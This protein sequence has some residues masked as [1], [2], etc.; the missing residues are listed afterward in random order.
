MV[1]AHRV[2][3]YKHGTLTLTL[4]QRE[5]E[6]L[7]GLP[8]EA[9]LALFADLTVPAD[10]LGLDSTRMGGVGNRH[11]CDNGR[12]HDQQRRRADRDLTA[13]TFFRYASGDLVDETQAF[14]NV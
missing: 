14:L 6:P 4:S 13:G 3:G 10:V 8:G 1:P 7:R 5:R 11:A 12:C 2:Q 9:L